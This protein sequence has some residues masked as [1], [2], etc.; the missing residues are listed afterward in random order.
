MDPLV[1]LYSALTRAGL[2]GRSSWTS[3]ERLG[4]D[5]A[6]R[7]STAEGAWAWHAEDSLGVV[8]VGARADLVTW[9]SNLYDLEPEPSR[10][11]YERADLI[12]VAG[13]IVHDATDADPLP[14]APPAGAHHCSAVA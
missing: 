3:W 2:D 13:D 1:G 7:G 9:S 12:I 5:A 4:L 10:L 14:E 8:R 6:L 11:L